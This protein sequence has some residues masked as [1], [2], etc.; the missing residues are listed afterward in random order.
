M[1]FGAS[2]GRIG[3]DFRPLLP[4]LFETR[5]LEVVGGYWTE[6]AD[7]LHEE[8]ADEHRAGDGPLRGGEASLHGATLV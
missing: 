5:L 2:L 6:A 4:S 1:F 3:A 7:R 8:L